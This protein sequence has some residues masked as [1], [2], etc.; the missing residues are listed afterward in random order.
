MEHRYHGRIPISLD[1][2]LSRRGRAIG[3]FKTYNIGLYGIAVRLDRPSDL[4]VNEVVDLYL[5]VKQDG[6]WRFPMKGLV[7]H[8]SEDE[9][10][11][12]LLDHYPAYA[13]FVS[14]LKGRVA[15]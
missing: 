12:M 10:G 8:R 6:V 4:A 2:K 3:L 7:V 11:I 5:T 15:A 9:L 13:G 1:I 14:G